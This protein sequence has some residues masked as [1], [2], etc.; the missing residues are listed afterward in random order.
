MNLNSGSAGVGHGI[1]MMSRIVSEILTG[2]IGG[3][4][5]GSQGWGV[6]G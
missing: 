5:V 3:T 1:E 4:V 6:R 2:Q